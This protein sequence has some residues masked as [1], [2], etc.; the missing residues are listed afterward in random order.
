MEEEEI[1]SVLDALRAEDLCFRKTL[2]TI[3]LNG[4]NIDDARFESLLLDILPT[5]PN[6]SFLHLRNNKI[7]SVQNI[8]KRIENDGTLIEVAQ[9]VRRIE[10]VKEGFFSW[11]I[12][13][14]I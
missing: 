4:C 8:A 14:K 7:Q 11:L 6:V 10:A 2:Q 5:M 12:K 13:R 1:D 9:P 3:D